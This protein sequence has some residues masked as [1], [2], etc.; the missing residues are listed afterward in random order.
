M[1]TGTCTA[2]TQ[3]RSCDGLCFW[4]EWSACSGETCDGRDN[5]CNGEVDEGLSRDDFDHCGDVNGDGRIDVTDVAVLMRLAA[6]ISTPSECQRGAGDVA[7]P[8]GVPS[9]DGIFTPDDART[10][11]GWYSSHTPC[12]LMCSDGRETCGDGC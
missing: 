6:G 9:P 11:F 8:G 7:S 5:N 12:C 2:G 3:T 1:T 10:V 4:S